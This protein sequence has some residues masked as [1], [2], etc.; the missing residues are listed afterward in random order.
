MFAFQIARLH[1]WNIPSNR[2]Q[3]VPR[4]S[5]AEARRKGE[6]GGKEAVGKV[7]GESE[8]VHVQVREKAALVDK[9]Q[10]PE[11]GRRTGT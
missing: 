11:K 2:I 3:R 4:V 7:H 1:V 5:S 8:G 6:Q 10:V 9:E